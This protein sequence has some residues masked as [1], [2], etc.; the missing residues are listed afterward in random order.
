MYKIE[1]TTMTKVLD[2]DGELVPDV[3]CDYFVKFSEQ[4]IPVFDYDFRG[5][6][7]PTRE[8]AEAVI[9][10]LEPIYDNSKRRFSRVYFKVQEVRAA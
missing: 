9:K 1:R 7:Y 3:D 10:Q 4:G 2:D 6:E 8:E 5:R